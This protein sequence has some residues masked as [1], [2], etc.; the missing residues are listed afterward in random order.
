M[1][2]LRPAAAVLGLGL[3]AA[4]AACAHRPAEPAPSR[5]YLYVWA[6]SDSVGGGASDFLAVVD[7]D[8]ASPTYAMVVATAPVGAAGTMP[9]HAEMTMPGTGQWLFANGFVAGRTWLFD[10]RNPLAP[11]VAAAIDSVPGFAKPHSFWRLPDGDVLATFQYGDG[12]RPGN[13]GGLVL[14]SPRGRVLRSASAADP[15]MP[16]AP[17]RTYSLDVAP[18]AD[19]AITTSAP[20][21]PVPSADVVQVWRLAGLEVLATLAVPHGASDSSWHMPFEVRFLPGD[22]LAFLNTYYCGLYVIAGLRTTAPRIEHV[23]SLPSPPDRSCGVPLLVGHWWIVPV[24]RAHRY[25][26]FDIADPRHPRRAAELATDTTFL[27]HWMARE[28]GGDRVVL[29]SGLGDHRVLLA[30]FDSARGVLAWDT[31]FHDPGTARLGVDLARTSWPHGAFGPA[32]PHAAIFSTPA[33]P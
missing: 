30:R 11:R 18:S 10:L 31:T 16:G 14:F 32:M 6:G 17:V 29:T 19:R 27:P 7:A 21:E 26:V 25:L 13:P 23:L 2:R 28:P 8:T 9:H 4:L 22:S 33:K 24:G 12:R 1:T 15:A 20:M 3:G 5:S